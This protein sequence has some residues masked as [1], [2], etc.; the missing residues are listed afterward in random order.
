MA[1]SRQE[2]I[3][4]AYDGMPCCVIS[5]SHKQHSVCYSSSEHSKVAAICAFFLLSQTPLLSPVPMT[6]HTKHHQ[7]APAF[8]LP[9]ESLPCASPFQ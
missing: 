2:P 7:A 5:T 3:K 8:P 4:V 1:G 6:P 9:E